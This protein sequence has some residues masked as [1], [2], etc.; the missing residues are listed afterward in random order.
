L[1]SLFEEGCMKESQKY[2]IEIFKLS[3]S[4]HDYEFEI[5]DKF[6]TLFENSIIQKG[7]VQAKVILDKSETFI[8]VNFELSGSIELTCD[9]SLEEF[10]FPVYV[11][12]SIIFKY[13]QEDQ[14]LSEEIVIIERNTQRLNIAQ[15]MYEFLGLSVPMKKLHPKYEDEDDQEYS[16]EGK[17]IYT[18]GG[19]ENEE[20]E[21][22]D[23]DFVDPRWDILKNLKNSNN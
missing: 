11:N 20:Q 3:N 15:Y 12:E 4:K 19:E 2:D 7:S 13:G 17:L 9:R 18:S 8:K 21:S 16:S 5:E 10:D 22:E 6:F 14:E 23:E 1:R